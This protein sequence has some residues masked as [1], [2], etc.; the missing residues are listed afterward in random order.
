M[1][2]TKYCGCVAA[3]L[4]SYSVSLVNLSL[5]LASS[6]GILPRFFQFPFAI[7]YERITN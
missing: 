6:L 3:I 7:L 4:Y 5:E 1:I 2:Q